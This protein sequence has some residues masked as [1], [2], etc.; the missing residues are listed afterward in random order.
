MSTKVLLRLAPKY[1]TK[2][3]NPE[4]ASLNLP[5]SYPLHQHSDL[6]IDEAAQLELRLREVKAYEI[7]GDLKEAI[8]K[9]YATINDRRKN[10]IGQRGSTR[11]SK[12]IDFQVSTV[13]K[14]RDRYRY[15]RDILLTLGMPEAHPDLQRLA[16]D[17]CQSTRM[18]TDKVQ[19]SRYQK[20]GNTINN[21][22]LSWI[23]K[24][25]THHEKHG[26]EWATESE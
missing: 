26:G 7:I 23:W 18:F 10:V 4:R 22:G 3:A 15:L 2:L 20:G 5:S 9:K 17:D 8:A 11:A 6:G 13:A 14:H 24:V 16:D 12:L 21:K 25:G 19:L 1:P